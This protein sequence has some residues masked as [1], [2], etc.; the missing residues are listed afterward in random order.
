M[1]SL[2]K[3]HRRTMS[4]SSTITWPATAI[5]MGDEIHGFW[6]GDVTTN[7]LIVAPLSTEI[8]AAWGTSGTTRGTVSATNGLANTNTLY[9]FGSAAHP[10][11][12]YCKTLATG[13]YNTWYMPAKDE[14]ITIYSNKSATPFVVANGT[15]G[16]YYWSSTEATGTT[17][18]AQR[19]ITGNY[20]VSNRPKTQ[21]WNSV[22]A[23]RRSTI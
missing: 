7:K 23:I 15:S 16:N 3:F 22:R 1:S 19:F 9:A 18:S 2:Q 4:S 12:Y 17:S 13:G 20:P 21:D 6:L 10:A 14:L 11:A 5:G 8:N